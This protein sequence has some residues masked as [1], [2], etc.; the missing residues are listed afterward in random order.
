MAGCDNNPV[1]TGAIP[2]FN[3]FTA[4][5]PV[6]P[7]LY[8]DVYSQEERIKA[9][10]CEIEKL[11]QYSNLLA[12]TINGIEADV[13]QKLTDTLA[14]VDKRLA[15]L[16]DELVKM[17]NEVV[18]TSM[19][20]DVTTGTTAPTMVAHRNLY[21]WITTFGMTIAEFNAAKPDMTVQELADCGLNC[22][23]WAA[24]SRTAF[25]KAGMGN[26]PGEYLYGGN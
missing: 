11:T 7:A 1:W 16:K 13:D 26:V 8:Y 15:S 10:C 9:I 4:S 20:W 14:K 12:E 2:P 25:G 21:H 18:G 24:L 17:I 6:I 19:D 5:P 23:G 3:C 22:Q